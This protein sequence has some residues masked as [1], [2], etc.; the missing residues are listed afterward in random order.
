MY[1]YYCDNCINGACHVRP[2]LQLR[3]VKRAPRDDVEAEN[4]QEGRGLRRRQQISGVD[5]HEARDIGKA[6]RADSR[7]AGFVG[8]KGRGWSWGAAAVMIEDTQVVELWLAAH[9]QAPRSCRPLE[10][11]DEV[12]QA[13]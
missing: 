10:C 4:C 7:R 9:R 8:G 11:T 1:Y 3:G 2:H 6:L 5:A 12:L 13:C